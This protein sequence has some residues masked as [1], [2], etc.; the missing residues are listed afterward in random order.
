MRQEEEGAGSGSWRRSYQK[1]RQG[2]RED[3]DAAAD[4]GK[5][6]D[7]RFLEEIERLH[8]KGPPKRDPRGP[9][10]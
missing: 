7:Q 6:P 8:G 2:S 1:R 3:G 9:R 10:R 5:T 4:D